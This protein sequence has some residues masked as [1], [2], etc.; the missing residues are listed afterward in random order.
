VFDLVNTPTKK[1]DIHPVPRIDTD[2]VIF[3]VHVFGPGKNPTVIVRSALTAAKVP[4]TNEEIPVM[5]VLPAGV[6]ELVRV[7]G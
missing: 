4:F 6:R 7:E 3:D 2:R 5:R 1:W